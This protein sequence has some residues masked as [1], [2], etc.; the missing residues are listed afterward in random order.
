MKRF[1]FRRAMAIAKKEK[2]HI[3]RDPFT[4]IVAIAIPVFLTIMFGFAIDF[5]IHDV[6]L[7]VFDADISQSSRKLYQKFTN[8]GYFLINEVHPLTVHPDR[9]IAM[10]HSKLS[11]IIPHKYEENLFNGR[12]GRV[13]VLFDGADNSTIGLITGYVQGTM[14]AIN[15]DFL[16]ENEMDARP[17]TYD[18]EVNINPRSVQIIPRF[19]F[20][21]EQTSCWFIVPGLSTVILAIL[22]TL[23]TSL[24]IAREW[25]T[26]SMELLLSTPARPAEIIFGKL[27]PYIFLGLFALS[28]IYVAARTVFH[29]PFTGSHLAYIAGS[30]LFIVTYLSLGLFISIVAKNQQIAMQMSLMIGYMPSMLLSG[31]IF[32]I[33]NMTE[34]WQYLTMLL[35]ARWYMVICRACYLKGASF[36]DLVV[37]FIALIIFGAL[38]FSLATKKFK[39]TLE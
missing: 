3:F 6:R 22:S 37:P 23:L 11:L 19:L 30:L 18:Y 17:K 2:M 38:M 4:L 16:Y 32:S 12:G 27:L 14:A 8:S 34:F 7:A 1:Q 39:G 28:L 35:P 25:E 10:E 15:Q 24:T 9:P 5:D 31:F 26:G 29:I 13:Q 33:Q 21:P 36:G 20:N